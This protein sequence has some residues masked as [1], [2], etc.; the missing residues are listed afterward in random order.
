MNTWVNLALV[1]AAYLFGGFSSGYWL[2]RWRT[3][4]DVRTHGSGGTGATNVGRILGRGGFMVVFLADMAKGAATVGLARWLD[5]SAIWTQVILI[6]IA[7]IPTPAWK[8]FRQPA[9]AVAPAAA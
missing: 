5:A 2:V 6:A 8:S 1:I 4:R 3:G 9:P 7:L